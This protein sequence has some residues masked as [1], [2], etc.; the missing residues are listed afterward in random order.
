[1]LYV[2]IDVH[3]KSTV[4]CLYNPAAQPARQYRTLT[5]P[6]TPEGFEEVLKPLGRQCHAAFEVGTQAQWIAS[7]VRPL[8]QRVEVA[9]PSRIPWLYR[10]GRK[11]DRMDARKLA[12]L[13]YLD[14]LPK[15]HLP[16]PDIS[17]WRSLINHR[18]ACVNQRTRLKNRIRTLLRA[19]GRRCPF[20]SCWTQEGRSWL[21]TQALDAARDLMMQMLLQDLDV[22]TQRITRIEQQ[23]DQISAQHPDAALLRTIPGIG[24]RT[25][26]AIVAFADT[27]QRF[28]RSRQFT[29]YFG[30][31]PTQDASGERNRH[32]HISK[33]G[34][35]VVR[36]VVVQAAHCIVRSRSALRTWFERVCRGQKNRFKKAI[37]ALGRKVLAIA[38]RMLADQTPYDDARVCGS[39]TSGVGK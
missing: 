33:R 8:V 18:R 23:L 2:G 12:T 13:L 5:R 14:Q 17:A 24:A 11:N 21:L 6:T 37:V 1:M 26:E 27:P 30:M 38:Y 9:N 28:G 10:D 29:S 35:S 19:F 32:G 39:A 22:A 36:W 3:Q 34:P 25:A 7:L 16:A 31:T 20:R 15:V 4:F